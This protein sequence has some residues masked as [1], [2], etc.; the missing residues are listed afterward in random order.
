MPA[1]TKAGIVVA[2]TPGANATSV[3]ELAICLMIAVSRRIIESDRTVKSGS[4]E[5]QIGIELDGRAVGIIGLGNIG[6][7]VATRLAAFG[8]KILVNDL[9][10][11]PEWPHSF[12]VKYVEKDEIYRKAD[13]ITLH[14]PLTELTHNMVGER[15]LKMMKKTAILINTARG[16]L[17]DESA[18]DKALAEKWIYGA[19]FDAFSVEPPIGF[20][21]L[22]HENLITTTHSGGG[23]PDSISRLDNF[24]I[25]NVIRVLSGKRPISV[26]NPSTAT[27]L[28]KV[29]EDEE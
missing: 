28:A 22:R 4:M 29:E 27:H 24:S 26:L 19:G 8:M 21:M 13:F 3:A 25:T 11:Y 18:L 15:E 20:P 17:V 5:P 7:R 9:V 12:R 1:G 16:G 6:K 10:T 2:N 23:T 14:T